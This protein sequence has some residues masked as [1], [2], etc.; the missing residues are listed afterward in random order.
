MTN[1]SDQKYRE[2]LIAHTE[3]TLSLLSNREK[4]R[5]ERMTCAAFLRGLGISFSLDDIKSV[6]NEPPDVIFGEA[7][8][9]VREL[10]DHGRRRGDEYK[11]RH[12]TLINSTSIEDTLLP[13]KS[14]KSIS[15]AELINLII[16]ALSKKASSYEK[17]VLS[18]LDA[19]VYVNLNSKLL[20]PATNIPNLDAL[21]AQG[22]RSVSFV[23][24]PY[25]HIIFTQD[26]AP[27]FLKRYTELTRNEWGN[28]STFFDID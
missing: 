4:T 17:T 20:D 21:I 6:K 14:I 24:V 25:S 27:D 18:N 10:L 28:P 9:E 3:E 22:W 7:C 12:E 11:E 5:R 1:S 2:D 15:Y 8:F 19:F 26:T 23:F 16:F 13:R